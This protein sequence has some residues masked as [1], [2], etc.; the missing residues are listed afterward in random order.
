MNRIAQLDPADAVGKA[1]ELFDLAQIKLGCVPNLL[2]VLANAPVAL[3]GFLSLNAALA[4]GVLGEKI[5]AQI[6]LA[7]AEINDC[8]Y[9]Q[10]ANAFAASALGLTE[11]D[12]KDARNITAQDER[13]AAILNLAR[14]IIV[15][16]GRLSESEFA[17]VRS[18]KLTDAEIMETAAN[19]ALNT[20]TNYV[21]NLARTLVDFPVVASMADDLTVVH[22]LKVTSEDDPEDDAY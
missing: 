13:T 11:A 22:Q 18:A 9:C 5:R 3:D 2:R 14:H 8:A 12:I 16:R 7:V 17:L 21:N 4:Q 19:V 20:L 1:K 6:A 10:S 15:E